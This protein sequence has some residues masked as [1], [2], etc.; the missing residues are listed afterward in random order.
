M[1]WALEI[2]TFVSLGWS[3]KW[4][5]S[6]VPQGQRSG[7]HGFMTG[8]DRPGATLWGRLLVAEAASGSLE[9]QG[10]SLL[11]RPHIRHAGAQLGL[12]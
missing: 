9:G 5:V 7:G 1:L 12:I 2:Q 11:L 10:G 8:D 6:P 4:K 3:A